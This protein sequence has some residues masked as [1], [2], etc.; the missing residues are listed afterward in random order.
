MIR[1]VLTPTLPPSRSKLYEVG[2]RQAAGYSLFVASGHIA[3]YAS[4][5]REGLG[6]KA[7]PTSSPEPLTTRSGRP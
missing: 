7:W 1:A 3:C 5:V 2:K 6:R 4:K